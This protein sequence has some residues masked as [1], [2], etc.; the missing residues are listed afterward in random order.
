MLHRPVG[1]RDPGEREPGHDVP[2]VGG[3]EGR[4]QRGDRDDGDASVEDA[5]EDLAD[6][7]DEQAQMELTAAEERGAGPARRDD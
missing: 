6:A 7:S 4:D 1:S 5:M 2:V 3:G